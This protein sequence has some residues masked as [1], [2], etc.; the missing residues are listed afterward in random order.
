M[1]NLLLLILLFIIVSCSKNPIQI[2]ETEFRTIVKRNILNPESF[3][4]IKF[5]IIDTLY[6]FSTGFII[7]KIKELSDN[8]NDKFLSLVLNK[9]KNEKKGLVVFD[10]II[11]MYSNESKSLINVFHKLTFN[12]Y[13]TVSNISNKQV[14]RAIENQFLK[15]K[16]DNLFGYN[17]NASF[18][19]INKTGL[20]KV[21]K[22]SV[23]IY[24]DYKLLSIILDNGKEIYINER[25]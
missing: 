17:V 14:L 13:K 12:E 2:A 4:L 24:D 8:P 16:Y 21:K 11:E 18:S 5:E 19:Y 1:K 10:K 6:D 23:F 9:L 7:E 22:A 20:K 25:E 15:Y 3:E